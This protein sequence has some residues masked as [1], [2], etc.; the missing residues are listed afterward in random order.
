M[1]ICEFLLNFQSDKKQNCICPQNYFLLTPQFLGRSRSR[2]RSFP[3]EKGAGAV[4]IWRLRNPAPTDQHS[5]TNIAGKFSKQIQHINFK[6]LVPDEW[7][8]KY[9]IN[10]TEKILENANE[11]KLRLV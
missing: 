6:F 2:P 7:S 8:V 11:Q 5:I 9:S 10:V 4:I 1:L 3:R